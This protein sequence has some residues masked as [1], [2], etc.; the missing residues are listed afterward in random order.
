MSFY[1][2]RA[3]FLLAVFALAGCSSLG[4]EPEAKYPTREQG[5]TAPSYG[6]KPKEGLFGPGGLIF[7]GPKKPNED[8]GGSGLGVNAF[9]WRASLDTVAFLP[10]AS[11]DPF[12]GVII[13]DWYSSPESPNERFKIN[14]FI[15]DRT[16]RADAVK[17]ALFRQVRDAQGNWLDAKVE[18]KMGTDLEN[19]VLTRARQLRSESAEAK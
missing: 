4:L 7:G 8:G 17:V 19:T 12:G 5:D 11:A 1:L 16:L 18:T 15:L 14:V 6:D 2:S 9:L 13:S 3:F 10:L